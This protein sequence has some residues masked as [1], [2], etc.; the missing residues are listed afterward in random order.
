[1]F[2]AAFLAFEDI[3]RRGAFHWT[4]HKKIKRVVFFYMRSITVSAT[5]ETTGMTNEV[6]ESS[7]N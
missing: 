2:I 5:A 3:T 6:T 4:T 1:M 7:I